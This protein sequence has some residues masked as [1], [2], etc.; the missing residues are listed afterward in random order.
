ML[1]NVFEPLVGL[2]KDLRLQPVLAE[3]WENP[4]PE[5]WRFHLKKGITFHDGTPLTAE[6]VR[7]SILEVRDTSQWEISDFLSAVKDVKT[8]DDLT[9]DIITE[10]PYAILNKL[11]FVYITKQNRQQ[12]FPQLVGT[13]PYRLV[14]WAK[15]KSIVVQKWEHYWG[16]A[17][18]VPEVH[19]LPV[20][21]AGDRFQS[22]VTSR[23][24][25]IYAVPPGV[26]TQKQP[27]GIHFIR[28]PGITVYY[29]GFNMKNDPDNPFSD[30]R[31]RQAFS[32]AIDRQ[33]L[34]RSALHGYGAV[35]TQPVAPLVFGFDPSLP[36]PEH[37]PEKAKQLLSETKFRDGFSIRLDFGSGRRPAAEW[38][39]KDLAAINVTVKLNPLPMVYDF[40]DSEKS[41]FYL[42]GWDCSSG[43]ASEFYEFCLHT[44]AKDFGDGNYG[45]FTNARIDEIAE[46]NSVTTDERLRREILQEAARISME[47]LPILP[48]Y[49]ED[50]IYAARDGINFDPRAD[51]E[52][53]ISDVRYV[54][55]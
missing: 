44:P 13:G 54:Q 40:L 30:L 50:D 32:L 15:G 9:L 36:E 41:D 55:K 48:V 24:D 38:I 34:V 52:I 27:R 19:F 31:V 23:S 45:S 51:S 8:I 33:G 43:D 3:S 49:I 16:D 47:E 42:A 2:D 21:D 35:P 14:S 29:L 25:V 39:Q 5:E 22:L 1:F 28:R 46:T 7:K 11:P 12:G 26:I 4:K 17:P 10:T 6:Y 37:N 20:P 18:A 53:Q